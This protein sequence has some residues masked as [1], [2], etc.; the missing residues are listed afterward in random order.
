MCNVVEE[1]AQEK[2][3]IQKAIDIVEHIGN[4]LENG[5]TELQACKIIGVSIETYEEAKKL[6]SE[7]S[8][9][10]ASA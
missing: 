1:Y 3:N 5:F 9:T 8:E 10:V 7:N 4:A 2:V 6:V